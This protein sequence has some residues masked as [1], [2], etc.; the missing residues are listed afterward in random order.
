MF[1][2][3]LIEKFIP[4]SLKMDCKTSVSLIKKEKEK[5]ICDMYNHFARDFKQLA[6]YDLH[7]F[8]VSFSNILLLNSELIS[9]KLPNDEN[10]H[11]IHI[12]Y[13]ETSC[14]YFVVNKTMSNTLNLYEYTKEVKNVSSLSNDL[15]NLNDAIIK[16]L[17]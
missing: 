17:L 11:S 9:M 8:R 5:Y 16:H 15:S 6:V 12:L 2:S 14:N 7:M 10:Y 13:N 4:W 3:Y 1:K